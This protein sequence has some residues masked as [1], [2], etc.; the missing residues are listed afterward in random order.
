MGIVSGIV[1]FIMIWWVTLFAVL[2][3]GVRPSEA[4]VP[5]EFGGAPEKPL[6]LK[7]VIATTL[8]SVVLWCVVYGLIDANVISFHEMARE[9]AEQDLQMEKSK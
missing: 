5:G 6:L 9:M 7:K 4:P 8:I 1:V 2:P 3:W